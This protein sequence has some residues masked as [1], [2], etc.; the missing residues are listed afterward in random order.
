MRKTNFNSERAESLFIIEFPGWCTLLEEFSNRVNL[1]RFLKW[2]FGERFTIDLVKDDSYFS[3]FNLKV[4]F[5]WI[6]EEFWKIK[7]KI[8]RDNVFRAILFDFEETLTEINNLCPK[9]GG[10]SQENN[11]DEIKVNFDE[12]KGASFSITSTSIGH[13]DTCKCILNR[14]EFDINTWNLGLIKLDSFLIPS[15]KKLFKSKTSIVDK[16]KATPSIRYIEK[17][18][19]TFRFNTISFKHFL[20]HKNHLYLKH[21]RGE[22]TLE[23][24]DNLNDS[25]QFNPVVYAGHFTGF[26]DMSGNPIYTGDIIALNWQDK[27]LTAPV[28]FCKGRNDYFAYGNYWDS[29]LANLTSIEVI[30]NVFFDL[31]HRETVDLFALVKSIAAYGIPNFPNMMDVR[32]VKKCMS[33]KITPGFRSKKWYSLFLKD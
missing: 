22:V 16:A 28:A 8:E 23:D 9:C 19:N 20:F 31:N 18:R 10:V 6:N 27:E 30:G 17:N 33:D 24:I 5:N 7:P 2:N 21:D 26:N 32:G 29:S 13:C 25:K 4:S 3:I 11:F 12:N 15:M 14:E 1:N